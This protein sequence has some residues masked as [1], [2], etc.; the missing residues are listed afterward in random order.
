MGVQ[1]VAEITWSLLPDSSVLDVEIKITP[2]EANKVTPIVWMGMLYS[3]F[4]DGWTDESG[5]SGEPGGTG[6]LYAGI[7][8]EVSLGVYA[9]KGLSFVDAGGLVLAMVTG[10]S[11]GPKEA[12]TAGLQFA[13]VPGELDALR[14]WLLCRRGVA[15]YRALRR[16]A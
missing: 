7:S 8:P 9:P 15:L 14:A 6:Q 12:A 16:H 5:V 11:N 1:G 4:L 10:E 3:G 13:V 2:D